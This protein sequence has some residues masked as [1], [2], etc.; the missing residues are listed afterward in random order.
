MADGEMTVCQRC[1]GIFTHCRCFQ[2]AWT[3]EPVARSKGLNQ[4]GERP[5]LGM[6][7]LH[8]MEQRL[9]RKAVSLGIGAQLE[10]PVGDAVNHAFAQAHKAPLIPATWISR[11]ELMATEYLE[12][13]PDN[14][15]T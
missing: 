4:R 5:V 12:G 8:K 3:G 14:Q 7:E 9:A 10:G 6:F 15:A 1:G 11:F 2:C 13:L